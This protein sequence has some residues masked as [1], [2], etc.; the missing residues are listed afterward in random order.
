VTEQPRTGRKD[1]PGAIYIWTENIGLIKF[2]PA[3]GD[4]GFSSPKPESAY[5]A[6]TDY[7]I[8]FEF[9][10]YSAQITY[11]SIDANKHLVVWLSD[12]DLTKPSLLFRDDEGWLG[13]LRAGRYEY[14]ILLTWGPDDLTMIVKNRVME[15]NR[16][17]LVS[18]TD[19]SSQNYSGECNQLVRIIASN[20]I[21]IG[22][23][24]G[25][26]GADDRL[27]LLPEGKIERIDLQE[28]EI[29]DIAEEWAISPDGESVAYLD[30]D[31]TV[32]I[33]GSDGQFQEAP[34]YFDP[35]SDY[36]YDLFTERAG[37]RW[38]PD[39]S[40]VLIFG[41]RLEEDACPQYFNSS[42]GELVSQPCWY[43]WDVKSA[44]F[45][46]WLTPEATAAEKFIWNEISTRFEAE[47]SPDGK[48]VA[49][50]LA[51]GGIED[52]LVFSLEDDSII[53]LGFS[54]ASKIRW[55]K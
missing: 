2:V 53:S 16:L 15:E 14:P 50:F 38:N 21:A 37:L 40:L 31:F 41:I 20:K 8:S 49:I 35:E 3:L 43:V 23:D 10:N 26:S 18:L 19:H 29:L 4:R 13:D 27:A 33:I 36:K 1:L 6:S 22:C 32:N 7:A 28:I 9:S 55:V 34:I 12:M 51:E 42:T 46:W 48:W 47:F 45:V 54:V 30:K 25:S 11:G 44:E 24:D 39:G 5:I 17:V 52:L